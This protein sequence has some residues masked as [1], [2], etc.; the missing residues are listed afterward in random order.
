MPDQDTRKRDMAKHLE[1]LGYSCEWQPDGW[2]YASHPVRWNVFLRSMPLGTLFH[3]T[4]HL[5]IVSDQ[6]RLAFLEFLNR[7]NATTLAVR[8]TL[9]R[10]ESN[11]IFVLRARAL[12]PGGYQRRAFGAWIDLWHRELERLRDGPSL[13]PE[14]ETEE[15]EDAS[16]A[17]ATVN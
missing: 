1:F 12:A 17:R 7:L 16:A 15:A 2:L 13:E 5:G 8:F 4:I 6:K 14:T 10:D 9:E 3:C 11:G